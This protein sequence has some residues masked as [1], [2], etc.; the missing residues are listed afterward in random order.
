M[1]TGTR[2]QRV[3]TPIC[4]VRWRPILEPANEANGGY[5]EWRDRTLDFMRQRYGAHLVCVF[6]HVDEAYGHVHAL[7]ANGGASVKP[8]HAGHAAALQLVG[9]KPRAD[10]YK[11]A[12]RALQ[13]EFHAQVA[14]PCGLARAG[15]RA[16]G[17]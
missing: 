3:D 11:A 14:G 4:S 8:L 9:S 1:A 15:P 2:K 10:A 5:V 17:D 7:V 13:D 12:E 16:V 6:E